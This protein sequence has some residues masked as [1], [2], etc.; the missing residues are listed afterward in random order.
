MVTMPGKSTVTLKANL[1]DAI[2]VPIAAGIGNRASDI[3]AYRGAGLMPDQIFIN[4]PE[5][6]GELRDRLAAGEATPF[7]QYTELRAPLSR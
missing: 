2:K 5:Y 7:D 3:T 4:L 6:T 1:L